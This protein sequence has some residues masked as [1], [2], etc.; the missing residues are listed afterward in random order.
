MVLKM[1]TNDEVLEDLTD[2]IKWLIGAI[3]FGF[4]MTPDKLVDLGAMFKT[5]DARIPST[6]MLV[7]EAFLDLFGGQGGEQQSTYSGTD[8][9]ERPALFRFRAGHFRCAE[10]HHG[11]P[12][13]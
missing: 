1:P 4:P 9:S 3:G 7:F 12:G 11:D 8:L 6:G 2:F 13:Q 10:G 5:K